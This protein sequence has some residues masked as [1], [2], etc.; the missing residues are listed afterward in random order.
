M[1]K[2][3]RQFPQPRFN[4]MWFWVVVAFVIIGYSMFGGSDPRPV[5]GDWNMVEELVE[6]GY[7]ERI[8]VKDKADAKVYIY[9]DKVESLAQS[10]ERF[11]N[12][13]LSGAQ[14]VYNTSGDIQYLCYR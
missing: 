8:E 2:N 1:E 13:P 12:M 4:F 10:D 3:K 11:Q 9:A 6:R 5:D 14:V 7:V